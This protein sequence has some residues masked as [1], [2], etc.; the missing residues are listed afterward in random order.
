[1]ENAACVKS[2]DWVM[3]QKVKYW[4]DPKWLTLF[5]AC[6]GTFFTVVWWCSSLQAQV[7]NNTSRVVK[8][9]KMAEDIAEI[10][11][12]LKARHP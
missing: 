4:A 1:M 6:F 10:K 12:I 8:I 2:R 5:G 9:D 11:G 3:P 7:D